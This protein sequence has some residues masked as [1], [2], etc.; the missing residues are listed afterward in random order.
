MPRKTLKKLAWLALVST[1]LS[2]LGAEV[3]GFN[4]V[5]AMDCDAVISDVL[6]GI[7]D[8]GAIIDKTWKDDASDYRGNPFPG[9]EHLVIALSGSGEGSVNPSR[10]AQVANNILMSGKLNHQWAKQ[11]ISACPNLS[12][13]GFGMSRTGWQNMFYRFRDG[14]VRPKVCV[15]DVSSGSGWG[16]GWCD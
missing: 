16:V 11:I 4:R 9:S 10:A 2:F 12:I 6:L 8:R 1:T 7:S 5:Y 13:V 14:Q 15:S 3:S